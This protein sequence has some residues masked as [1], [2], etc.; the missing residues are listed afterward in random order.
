MFGKIF[1][2]LKQIIPQQT[3]SY[4]DC[5]LVEDC[6]L[7]A[8]PGGPLSPLDTADMHEGSPGQSTEASSYCQ[9]LHKA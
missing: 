7:V 6:L 5:L 8:T 3:E 2:Y 9:E 1:N 4:V